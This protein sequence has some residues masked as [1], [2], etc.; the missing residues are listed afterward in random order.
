MHLVESVGDVDDRPRPGRGGAEGRRTAGR[1]PA[2]RARRWARRGS[3]RGP[4]PRA[5]GDLDDLPL[6]DAQRAR[7]ARSG[8]C[9][10]PIWSSTA[11]ARSSHGAPADE[12][13]PCRKPA[14]RDV[15]GH[16][17][18]R[19][20]LELLVDHPDAGGARRDG[21]QVRDALIADRRSRPRRACSRRRG[22]GRASTCRRRSRRAARGS[23]RRR[24]R[25]PLR[26][27]PRRRRTTSGR[28]ERCSR[29]CDAVCRQLRLSC[30]LQAFG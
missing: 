24:R 29:A 11:L 12:P 5:R 30:Y 25:G 26:A 19:R 1:P 18:R 23:S 4:R 8:R 21:R 6:A 27:G 10:T 13:A 16:G 17:Q 3:A 7:R 28:P 2:A 22:S 15:L 14:E 20:I 9:S